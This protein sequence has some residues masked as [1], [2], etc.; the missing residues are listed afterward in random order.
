MVKKFKNEDI[1]KM[2]LDGF[3]LSA[4]QVPYKNN[5]PIRIVQAVKSIIGIN[6]NIEHKKLIDWL[7]NFLF[8]FDKKKIDSIKLN[9]IDIPDLVVLSTLD[10]LILSNDKKKSKEYLHHIIN[11]ATPLYILE[12]FIEISLK[13]KNIESLLF[14]WSCYRSLLFLGKNFNPSSL[15][16]LCLDS[17]FYDRVNKNN[18]KKLFNV[19]K[20]EI[21][22]NLDEIKKSSFVRAKNILEYLNTDFYLNYIQL[23]KC[24]NKNNIK[25]INDN[26][27]RYDLLDYINENEI[28]EYIILLF[29]SLRSKFKHSNENVIPDF[30]NL[31]IN[32]QND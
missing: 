21:M 18:D 31:L 14:C 7:E 16:Y 11:A 10:E 26:A 25:L 2:K 4:S 13:N 27:G 9:K 17:L 15:L 29:D 5:H 1:L 12:F 30:N 32:L 19:N 8:K 22:C 24:I 28:N 3:F 6:I 20:F 23:D